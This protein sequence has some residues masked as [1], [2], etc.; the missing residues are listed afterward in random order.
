MAGMPAASSA[1]TSA[2]GRLPEIVA[3]AVKSA[4]NPR[5]VGRPA[6]V[7]DVIEAEF[8]IWVLRNEVTQRD[9]ILAALVRTHGS[10]WHVQ[11]SVEAGR[12]D[13]RGAVRIVAPA[14]SGVEDLAVVDGE[15]IG[16]EER[17]ARFGSDL[18]VRE[19]LV[20]PRHPRRFDRQA[21]GDLLQQPQ[22][23][24]RAQ[25]F[26]QFGAGRAQLL[27]VDRIE[28]VDPVPDERAL[29]PVHD[30]VAD[31]HEERAAS[32][33]KPPERVDIEQLRVVRR[34][35]DR[36]GTEVGLV[37]RGLVVENRC[38]ARTCRNRGI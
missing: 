19:M 8:D 23:R 4:P 13:T 22:H 7:V 20:P 9:A 24:R 17:A 6:V 21:V 12:I 10:A 36:L 3:A 38:R 26:L 37:D 29:A 15:I 31:A 27:H 25:G 34:V 32:E 14:E 11:L 33:V 28:D 1:A 5:H 30:L 2:G 35:V 16:A 18:R